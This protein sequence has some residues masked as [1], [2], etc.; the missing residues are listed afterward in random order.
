LSGTQKALTISS[1][2]RQTGCHRGWGRHCICHSFTSVSFCLDSQLT[3][4]TWIL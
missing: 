1:G 2:L 3:C 4:P